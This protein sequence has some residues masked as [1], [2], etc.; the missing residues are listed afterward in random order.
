MT[1]M[2]DR[3][4]LE[5]AIRAVKA[6]ALHDP[7]PGTSDE[8]Y[9]TAIR[10]CVRALERLTPVSAPVSDGVDRAVQTLVQSSREIR[11]QPNTSRSTGSGDHVSFSFRR[12]KANQP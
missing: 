5:A 6:E 12:G 4:T 3:Y 10:H 8:A 2:L 11:Q 7:Q 1:R 9:D